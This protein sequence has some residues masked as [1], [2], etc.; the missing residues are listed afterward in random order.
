[1]TVP[2]VHDTFM[3]HGA[4]MPAIYSRLMP[5]NDYYYYKYIALEMAMSEIT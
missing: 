4:N 5:S 1:M 2:L 3:H